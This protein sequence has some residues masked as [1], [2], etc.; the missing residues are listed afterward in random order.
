MHEALAEAGAEDP[1]MIAIRTWE[2]PLG[3]VSALPKILSRCTLA[4][5]TKT[6]FILFRK[7]SGIDN[8]VH[9][10]FQ[11]NR[12]IPIVVMR[13]D[14]AEAI[15]SMV[16]AQLGVAF[17]P[18]W[19][20]RDELRSNRLRVVK[21]RETPPTKRM[22]LYRMRSP[23]VPKAIEA[24]AEEMMRQKWDHLHPSEELDRSR[25]IYRK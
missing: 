12:F 23:Y 22:C 10:Y 7:G 9:Q 21:L 19:A 2:A 8:S 6:P 25:S 24:F 13:S 18:L 3:L 1:R 15:K 5:L 4:A 14:S 11:E 17:V 20:A 16:E